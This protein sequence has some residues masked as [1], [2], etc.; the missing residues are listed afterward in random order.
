MMPRDIVRERIVR[1]KVPYVA[2][3]VALLA[4]P[5]FFGFQ[6]ADRE[7]SRVADQRVPVKAEIAELEKRKQALDKL[8]SLEPMQGQIGK[9][10]KVGERRGEWSRFFDGLHKAMHEV[11]RGDFILRSVHQVEVIEKKPAKP[12]AKKEEDGY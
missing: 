6:G 8:K 5:I 9:L 1:A 12:G 4:A 11:Q 3:G 10:A 7:L 2:A